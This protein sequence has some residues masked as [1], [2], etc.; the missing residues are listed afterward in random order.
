MAFHGNPV[1]VLIIPGLH[2]SGPAHW[3][4]WLQSHSRRSVRVEQDDWATPDIEAWS[5]R[6]GETLARE[7]A[8]SLRSPAS[9]RCPQ[10]GT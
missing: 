4:T 7:P 9:A 10:P 6:I 1:R 5:A 3:Q 2:S 8:T